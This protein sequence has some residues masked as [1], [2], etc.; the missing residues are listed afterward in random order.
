MTDL[1]AVRAMA[2]SP[3]PRY[4]PERLTAVARLGLA[5]TA[6]REQVEPAV[7]DLLDGLAARTGAETVLV[8]VLLADTVAVVAARG[9]DGWIALAGGVPAEWAMCST[10]ARQAAAYV[11]D[12]LAADPAWADTPLVALDGLRAYAGVPLITS[13]GSV[14]GTVCALGTAPRT[15]DESV[16]EELALCAGEVLERLEQQAEVPGATTV[17]APGQESSGAG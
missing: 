12:D 10:T 1:A 13:E 11:V 7:A 3:N 9:L 4:A 6:A 17:A 14:I 2:P 16:I 8:N 15:L 5:G